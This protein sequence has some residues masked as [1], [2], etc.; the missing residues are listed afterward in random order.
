MFL[1][2]TSIRVMFSVRLFLCMRAAASPSTLASLR[3]LEELA[4]ID[5][6]Q[7]IIVN[8]GLAMYQMAQSFVELQNLSGE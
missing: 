8:E 5:S 2:F 6:S 4:A 3:R 7:T 1:I